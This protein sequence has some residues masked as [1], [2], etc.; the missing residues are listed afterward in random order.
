MSTTTL[1]R[2]YCTLR[3]A[4]TEAGTNDP[5]SALDLI[6]EINKASRWIDDHCKRDFLFHDHS[7]TA[8]V[9][10]E[11]WCALGVIYFPW[12]II[13]LTEIKVGGELFAPS[14]YRHSRRPSS[15]TSKIERDGVWLSASAPSVGLPGATLHR[16]APLIELKGTFGFAPASVKPNENPSPDL[17][18]VVSQACAAIAAIRSGQV[19]REIT[20]PGGTREAITVRSVP[21]SVLDPLGTYK[22][23]VV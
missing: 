11:S 4:Q 8:F 23:A 16:M 12:P 6:L 7:T 9:V 22:I 17:P 21:K 18:A 1:L 3:D 10:P 20:G 14:L 5:D 15:A 13:T 19:R 2:P